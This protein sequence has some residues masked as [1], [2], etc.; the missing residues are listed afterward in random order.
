MV[1]FKIILPFPYS[2]IDTEHALFL[3][4]RPPLDQCLQLRLDARKHILL[5]LS[6][7]PP[8]SL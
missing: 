8:N 5:G 3:T 6:R 2:T 4:R 7:L 1:R